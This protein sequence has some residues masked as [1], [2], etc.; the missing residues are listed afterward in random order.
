MTMIDKLTDDCLELVFIHCGACPL[1]LCILSQVCRRW[2]A[3]ARQESLVSCT[4]IPTTSKLESSQSC[5]SG[6]P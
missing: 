5:K 1:I 4:S 2:H 6:V 3:I